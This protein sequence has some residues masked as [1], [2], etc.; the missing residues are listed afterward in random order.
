MGSVNGVGLRRRS[1]STPFTLPIRWWWGSREVETGP[2]FLPGSPI[3][4]K[5]GDE[6]RNRVWVPEETGKAEVV[7]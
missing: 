6:M 7:L 2:M 1:E 3:L 5:F 4:A